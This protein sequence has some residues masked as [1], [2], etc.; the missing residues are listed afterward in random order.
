MEEL[1]GR[2]LGQKYQ[3]NRKIGEGGMGSV[4]EAE[5]AAI[6]RRVAVKVMNRTEDESPDK[7]RRFFREA[8]AAGEI[9]HPNIVEIYDVGVE[10]DGTAYMVMELLNGISLGELLLK[11]K[12]LPA[13]KTVA[14]VVQVL[15]ALHAT[16]EKGIIHRD[17]KPDNIFLSV[18]ARMRE[19][20]KLL[21]FGIAKIQAGDFDSVKLTK[22]ETVLGT[23]HYLSP[24]QASGS[25]D[26]DARI[27]IWAIG[28]M[29]YEMLA[30]QV[31]FDGE[32][33]NEVISN[34]LMKPPPSLRQL[35]PLV[36]EELAQI[37]AKAMSKNREE[38]YRNVTELMR[39]LE[40]LNRSLTDMGTDAARMLSQF[41]DEATNVDFP[42]TRD[43]PNANSLLTDSHTPATPLTGTDAPSI[44]E[45][46]KGRWLLRLVAV[47]PVGIVI[48]LAVMV[49][50][51]FLEQ[52]KAPRTDASLSIPPPSL[53]SHSEPSPSGHSSP[54]LISEKAPLEAAATAAKNETPALSDEA[55]KPPANSKNKVTVEIADL[56]PNARVFLGGKRIPNPYTVK[57]SSAET[58]LR[59]H[60]PGYRPHIQKVTPS[61]DLFL[62]IELK[63]K[64]TRAA[65]QKGDRID[66]SQ[67]GWKDNPFARMEAE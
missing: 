62:Q 19:D 20:V 58:T 1:L 11:C 40:P 41:I 48:A 38:R 4:W 18:D 21:D 8:K 35:A 32:N 30:G 14:I 66:S 24:E 25:S 54:M 6:R 26:I 46:S 64:P 53:E 16:H 43:L 56:P 55:T 2:I 42:S 59:V 45:K 63:K 22:P 37:I 5:H 44:E 34:I 7:L 28:V 29:M 3:L 13:G 52:G 50:L 9:G 12:T 27:D 47:I 51:H 17:L 33:Y 57:R 65:A 31:P 49:M 10:D 60:C 36:S 39:D 23:P 67:D 61:G 15:S